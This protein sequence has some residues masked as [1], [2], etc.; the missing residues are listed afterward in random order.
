MPYFS[1]FGT[2]A[3]PS[4]YF[5]HYDC[6][7]Q[8]CREEKGCYDY[9]PICWDCYDKQFNKQVKLAQKIELE[10]RLVK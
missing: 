6:L 3:I 2:S 9:L 1:W 7:C 5:T 10:W 8:I 4:F